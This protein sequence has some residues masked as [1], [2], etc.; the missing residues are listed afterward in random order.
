MSWPSSR[1]DDRALNAVR[2]RD[3]ARKGSEMDSHT[4]KVAVLEIIPVQLVA[5]LFCIHHVLIDDESGALGVGRDALS[6]LSAGG[7]ATIGGERVQRSKHV[8]DGPV[9]SEQVEQ[10]LWSYVVAGQSSV[11]C[12]SLRAMSVVGEGQAHLR[13]FTNKALSIVAAVSQESIR[14]PRQCAWRR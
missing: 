3:K 11:I 2:V 5:R 12:W 1:A 14:I 13:F 8:P 10:L 9:L 7:S 4:D 6:N